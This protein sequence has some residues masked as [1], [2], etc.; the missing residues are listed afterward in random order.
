MER[1]WEAFFQSYTLHKF[2]TAA[3][4]VK[5]LDLSFV[6]C[7]T[8]LSLVLSNI[9]PEG[10]TWKGLAQL[11]LSRF[12]FQ[13]QDLL[14]FL[15]DHRHTL[16][17]V[18]FDHMVLEGPLPWSSFATQMRSISLPLDTCELRLGFWVNGKTKAQHWA[19]IHQ[20][21]PRISPI[22]MIEDYIL[23]RSDYNPF[24]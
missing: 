10:A 15:N 18:R 20:C 2:L 14:R 19:N 11:H 6:N 21:D 3:P 7:P 12:R 24:N 5:S 16:K 23:S 8:T 17:S 1:K 13:P 4:H 9:V 22:V